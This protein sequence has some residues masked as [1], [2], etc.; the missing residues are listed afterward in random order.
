MKDI[1]FKE[2]E[3]LEL[4]KSTAELKEGI[5]SIAAILNKHQK[6]ELYFGIEDNGS[7]V[8]QDIGKNTLRNVSKSISD[9]VEPKIYPNVS[10]IS[11]EGRECVHVKFQGNEVPYFAYGRARIRV[12]D[13]DRQLSAVELKNLILKI[14]KNELRWDYEVC[15]GAK[16][17]DI[18]DTKLK[19][20]LAE[21]GLEYNGFENS[22]KKLNLISGDDVLNAAVILFG[23]EP[24]SF[25]QNARL[26][27]A[28]FG[29]TD[30][31]FVVDMQ[32]FEGDLF[33]LIEEAQ[34]Y[35]LKNIHIGMRLEGL[36][37]VD[38]PEI[39]KEA[40]REAIVNAFTHRNYYEYDSVNVAVFKDRV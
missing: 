17:S 9:H 31:S 34:K 13:E 33:S 5:I 29:K 26:R 1:T 6:G 27:C 39:D 25:Y 23:N 3:T 24:E 21:A 15:K 22:L 30:T 16:L 18:S 2:T 11:L 14:N 35:V 12:G 20:F 28:V 7:V 4:K 40:L 38:V 10:R 32:D 36:R 37:R 19:T 8:G